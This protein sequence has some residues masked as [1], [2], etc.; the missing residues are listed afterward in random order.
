MSEIFSTVVVVSAGILTVANLIDRV[1]QTV[2]LAKKPTA[3][4]ERRI[5]DLERK[6]NEE[7]ARRFD[8]YDKKIAN[9]E[10]G[11]RVT[12][13][14]ILELLKHSIDGNNT[15]GLRDAEK[16]LNDYLIKK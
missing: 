13:R 15:Q 1:V 3:D 2:K 4:L 10:E 16:E 11:T 7:F 12:Q 9:I 14:A 6:T 8:S 5:A